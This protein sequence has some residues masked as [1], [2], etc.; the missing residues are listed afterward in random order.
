MRLDRVGCVT[1]AENHRSVG[2]A[3]R[4]GMQVVAE[5]AVPRDDG[6]GTVVVVILQVDRDR[7]FSRRES[8]S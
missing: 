2:V 3:K 1:G 7:R 5:E 4:L 8:R 6:S